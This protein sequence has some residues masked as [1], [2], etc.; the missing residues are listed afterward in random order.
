MKTLEELL[1]NIDVKEVIGPVD[2]EISSLEYDSRKCAKGS[3]FTAISGAA[4]DGHNFISKALELGASSI[5]C[6]RLPENINPDITYILC[7]NSRKTLALMAHNFYDNPTDNLYVIGV[8]GTNGKTTITYLLKSILEAAGIKTALIGTTGIIIDSEFIPA[9]HT[10]PE[11]T[12]LCKY[13]NMIRESGCS[14]VIM[15]TSSHALEQGRTEGINFNGG[16]FTN[17]TH[18]HLDYHGSMDKYASAKKILFDI[19]PSD[20]LAVVNL[21]DKY[22]EEMITECKANKIVRIGRQGHTDMKI[23]SEQFGLKSSYFKLGTNIDGEE[24]LLSTK[25]TGMFNIY[26]AAQAAAYC[27]NIGIDKKLIASG[28]KVAEGAPGR[29]QKV[30]LGNGAIGIVD[31]AHTPDA[32]EKA[33][34]AC[35]ETLDAA[36][37][38]ENRLITVFG[39]G[40]DRDKS[41][42][43]PMGRIA[44][45]NSDLT[46]VTSDNPRTENPVAIINDIF[47]GI[48]DEYIEDTIRTEDRREA[49]KQAVLLSLENDIIL[50]AGK[51]HETYQVIGTEKSH[52][53]DVEELKKHQ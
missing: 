28:L 14:H 17:L 51:G 30:L 1:K 24:L 6:E 45:E 27:Y 50:V 48:D 36:G 47:D 32:L 44:V 40:G 19:L 37:N 5:I 2:I 53:D 42:R 8:T 3:L 34:N 35:R 15:E 43:A 16:I 39:C 23:S 52:F 11:S 41:K 20:G 29:M 26:N 13:F 4:F 9:T 21:D 46:I 18:E 7:N 49:I 10:T 12:E 25:L 22:S 38:F 31:Y 33:I